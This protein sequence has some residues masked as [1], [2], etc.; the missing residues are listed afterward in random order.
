MLKIVTGSVS[1]AIL[2]AAIVV[3]AYLLLKNECSLHEPFVQF[4]S[5]SH[6]DGAD[7]HAEGTKSRKQGA[8]PESAKSKP[9]ATFELRIAEPNKIEGTYYA[10]NAEGDKGDWGHKFLCDTKIGEFSLALFTLVLVIFT[11]GLWWST[12]S[13]WKAGRDDFISTHRPRVIVRSIVLSWKEETLQAIDVHVVNI[14]VNA[15][16]IK[17]FGC[18]LVRRRNTT[19]LTVGDW[20]PVAIQPI[21]L[22][23]GERHI[24]SAASVIQYGDH[25]LFEDAADTEGL[26]RICAVGAIRYADENGVVRETGFLRNYDPE[27]DTFVRSPDQ[28]EEYED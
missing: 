16:I 8:A 23:S 26:I 12:H 13:L 18:Q 11:G 21:R 24:F 1:A 3:G 28:G 19:W 14:G 22:T 17:E 5:G 25:E 2:F 10:E 20:N 15:G 9:S 4:Q 6:G 27:S 7:N